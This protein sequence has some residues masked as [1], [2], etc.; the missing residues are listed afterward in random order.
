MLAASLFVLFAFYLSVLSAQALLALHRARASR[1]WDEVE[2]TVVAVDVRRGADEDGE[3]WYQ[4]TLSYA[5][6]YAG[7]HYGSDRLSY[8]PRA[9][10]S[11]APADE[12]VAGLRV[13]DPVA[14]RVNPRRPE[15]SVVSPGAD[16]SL[17]AEVLALVALT[18]AV[19]TAPAWVGPGSA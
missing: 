11:R 4:P 13:G 14:I 18:L 10:R 16:W 5:Y 12:S 9:W 1:D 6:G 19:A 2:G 15:Q 17:Y 8:S 3:V 7:R